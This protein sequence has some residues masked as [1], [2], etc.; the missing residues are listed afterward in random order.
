MYDDGLTDPF[1]VLMGLIGLVS[2]ALGA[3]RLNPDT[4]KNMLQ[5]IVG[6]VISIIILY[7]TADNPPLGMALFAIVLFLIYLI[8]NRK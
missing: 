1:F 7:A 3:K 6:I 5:G 4:F 2:L 8:Y